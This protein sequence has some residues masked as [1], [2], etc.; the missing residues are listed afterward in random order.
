[1]ATQNF[2][3]R[4]L[5]V[6][7]S[8]GSYERVPTEY[9][10]DNNPATPLLSP[11]F[12]KGGVDD[13]ADISDLIRPKPW[14]RRH[15]RLIMVIVAVLSAFVVAAI[16]ARHELEKAGAISF[17]S[18]PIPLPVESAANVSEEVAVDMPKDDP[19]CAM[20]ILPVPDPEETV[21]LD[22][23]VVAARL[24]V[25]ALYARQSSSI[26]HAMARYSLKTGRPPPQNYDKWYKFAREK[27][28]L[29]DDYDQIHRDFKPFYQLAEDDPLFFQ[30][31]IDI[32]ANMVRSP[33][34]QVFGITKANTR[35]LDDKGSKGN[36]DHRDKRWASVY[37][38]SQI[39]CLLGLLAHYIQPGA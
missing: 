6:T 14:P 7:V 5:S 19:G 29:I 10:A 26:D 25:D 13:E 24:S 32:G 23:P 9:A 18:T 34:F 4:Q 17:H 28:C 21:D 12:L 27:S 38:E 3:F 39:N 35:P 36:G 20:P 2:W 37:A 22:N 33:R 1:M 15:Q 30:R 16:V 11:S 8:P 31:M